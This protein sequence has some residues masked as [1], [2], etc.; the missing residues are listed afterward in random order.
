LV[1]HC[2]KLAANGFDLAINGTRAAIDVE[3][4]VQN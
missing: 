2:Q 4:V 1:Q 3:D